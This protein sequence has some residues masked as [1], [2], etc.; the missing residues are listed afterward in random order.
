MSAVEQALQRS[1]QRSGE[2]RGLTQLFLQMRESVARARERG[3]RGAQSRYEFTGSILGNLDARLLMKDDERDTVVAQYT[4]AA[5]ELGI[6]A[7]VPDPIT[8]AIGAKHWDFIIKPE[9]RKLSVGE[10]D[11]LMVDRFGKHYIEWAE[12]LRMQSLA[13][14]EA[15]VPPTEGA[16][17]AEGAEPIAPTPPMHGG[18]ASRAQE[19]YGASR[20]LVPM[21]R[22]DAD[23]LMGL[24]PER[25]GEGGRAAVAE[26]L[27][28]EPELVGR[29]AAIETQEEVELERAFAVG[30]L[31]SD[32][33]AI[34]A[35]N[36]DLDPGDVARKVAVMREERGIPMTQAEVDNAFTIAV[37]IDEERRKD[38]AQRIAAFSAETSRMNAI[39]LRESGDGGAPKPP[40]PARVGVLQKQESWYAELL[41]PAPQDMPWLIRSFN[42][43]TGET[44]VMNTGLMLQE[45]DRP[46]DLLSPQEKGI[47]DA[48][49]QFTVSELERAR[50]AGIGPGPTAPPGETVVAHGSWG[51]NFSNL[52]P[53]IA[54]W[55]QGKRK[56][57]KTD[58]W[59][60]EQ[61]E[62]A[63]VQW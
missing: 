49:H 22:T 11:S 21:P 45:G 46:Y 27:G 51:D 18:A 3:L 50:L 47:A 54:T 4:A 56:E 6:E 44:T 31:S 25:L 39:R 42:P 2:R 37:R 20:D 36:P 14:G 12:Q 28:V 33:Q 41:R 9:L 10:V 19:L 15:G 7:V 63:G 30:D 29:L 26:A 34:Y 8:S 58:E 13:E 23:W 62:L 5:A 40:T 48:R 43:E 57:G 52:P 32:I 35:A 17:P 16:P 59:I 61:L 1:V 60:T 55:A 38:E 53:K 24:D